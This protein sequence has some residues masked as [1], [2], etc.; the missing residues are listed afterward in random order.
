MLAPLWDLFSQGPRPEQVDRVA[1][2]SPPTGQGAEARDME[3]QLCW[4][5]DTGHGRVARKELFLGGQSR[6]SLQQRLPHLGCIL[7]VSS[8]QQCLTKF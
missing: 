6:L 1:S 5:T 7:H 2:P 3:Q 8:E 4:G